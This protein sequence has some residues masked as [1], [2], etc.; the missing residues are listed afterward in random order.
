VT[1]H[2]EGPIKPDGEAPS[3]GE[4]GRVSHR[5]VNTELLRLYWTIGTVILDRQERQ[6][7]GAKVISRLAQDLQ[8]ASPELSGL[9]RS[10]LE[11]MRRF[12]AA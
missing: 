5:T 1:K 2:T 9:S 11:Y 10:N 3:R 6:G 4:S 7:W 8:A 12:A